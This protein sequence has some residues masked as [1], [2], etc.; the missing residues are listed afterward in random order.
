M[1][2]RRMRSTW[3]SRSL[4]YVSQSADCRLPT[5]YCLLLTAYFLLPTARAEESV[6]DS[7]MYRNPE[8]AMPRT[9]KTFAKGLTELWLQALE[10]PEAD[11]KAQ[12][13]LA[14]GF[15]HE[16]GMKGL[17][18]TV[19]ALERELDRPDQHPTVRLAAVRAL[20][21]LDA[22]SAAPSL[23][24][25]AQAGDAELREMI[26][27]VLA[28]WNYAPAGA[29]WLER[30]TANSP[31]GRG[32]VLAIQGLAAVRE[33]Q[34]IPRLRDLVLADTVPAPIRLE[35]ARA[36]AV[37]RPS[38]FEKDAEQLLA[39]TNTRDSIA[40]LAA[41][42]LLRQHQGDEAVRILLKLARDPN[43]AAAA[44][45]LARLIEID[46]TLVV[47]LLDHVLASTDA[48]VRSLGVDVLF[49]RPG[50]K[51]IRL[52]GDRLDDPHPDVRAQARRAL[53]D[54]AAKQE[55]HQTVIREGMRL[56][57]GKNWRGQEQAAILLAQLDHKPVANR[58]V[59][60]LNSDRGEVMV[61]T[62]W[63]L[64]QLAV[65]DTLPAVL[66]QVQRQHKR[67]LSA[68]RTRSA[69]NIP[70]EAVNGQLTQLAQ[71]LGQAKYRPADATL[72]EMVPRFLSGQ[73]SMTPLG[74]E[75]R[76]AACWA[77]GFIHEGTPAS[78]VVALLIGRLTDTPP[79]PPGPEDARVRSMSA[80]SMGRMKAQE[81]LPI[82]RKYF[83][84]LKAT[85]EIVPKACAWAVVQMTGEKMPE[86]GIIEEP[87]Q[88]W[89]L[90]P[91]Q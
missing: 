85:R 53:H 16:H 78:D 1:R 34:A 39:D 20:V 17:E 90:T 21:A 91:S 65:P 66:E 79:G 77:L 82:L 2:R 10:R 6:I 23:L 88:G 64:R 7:P 3:L 73:P 43:P 54:L 32:A 4:A 59:E 61:S 37:L 9:V 28:R 11:Y 84:G 12:A 67:M 58:L 22:R 49:R 89:F 69:A 8:L 18:T 86:P 45:A 5:A 71:F 83:P 13:A 44:V 52:L 25:Q 31:R 57:S 48:K 56:V 76:A 62:A 72:R 38:G 36:L 33:A 35:A 46:P 51:H 27:P 63:A 74:A 70:V 68:A 75:V 40:H 47:P 14:I 81:A 55:F 50:D 15:A 42:S 24:R 29:I 30:I 87:Q 26:E 80:I 19:P 60:L 41:A